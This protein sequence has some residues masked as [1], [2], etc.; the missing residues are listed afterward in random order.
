MDSRAT[1]V[2]QFIARPG[3]V[4]V[5]LIVAAVFA[6]LMLA[7]WRRPT[8]VTVA[9]EIRVRNL[10][11]LPLRDVK[12]GRASYGNIGAGETTTYRT[13][14]PAYA[15]ST[16]R[17]DADGKSYGHIPIDYV[18]ETPLGAGQFTFIIQMPSGVPGSDFTVAVAKE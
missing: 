15:I 3:F 13:W 8:T 9:S 14:G 16:I 17:F 18:G 6:P 5:P 2:G 11:A 4:I 1:K 10:S 12:L 7:L